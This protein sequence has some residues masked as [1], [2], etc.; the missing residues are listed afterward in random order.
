MDVAQHT[1]K[2]AS[3]EVD[4]ES[5]AADRSAYAA[6]VIGAR[7]LHAGPVKPRYHIGLDFPPL[8]RTG[9]GHLHSGTLP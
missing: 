4:G 1:E 2:S 9:L 6:T 7:V 5:P 8:V 3:R